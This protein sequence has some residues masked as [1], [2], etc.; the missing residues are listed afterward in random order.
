MNSLVGVEYLQFQKLLATAVLPTR[1]STN[2][3]GLDLYAA[4][5]VTLPVGK[6]ITVRTGL[7]VA[8]PVG[9][10]GRIAPRSGLAAKHGIDTLAGVIDSDYRGEILCLLINHGTDEFNVAIGDRIAQLIIEKIFIPT[11]MWAASLSNSE[12]SDNGFG[13]TGY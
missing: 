3:A 2:A 11:P 10:Y 4:E 7:A 9:C 6:Y 13:S 1:G 5:S 12:R 8:I